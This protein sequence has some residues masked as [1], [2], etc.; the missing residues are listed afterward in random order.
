MF[1]LIKLGCKFGDR[2][3]NINYFCFLKTNL[4]DFCLSFLL[5]YVY[6]P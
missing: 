1:W 2:F 5:G 6:L 3:D 4:S